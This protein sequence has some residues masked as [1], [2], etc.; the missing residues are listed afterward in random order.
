MRSA[1]PVAEKQNLPILHVNVISKRNIFGDFSPPTLFKYYG[2]C[3]VA[4]ISKKAEIQ[5]SNFPLLLSFFLHLWSRRP[6][7]SQLT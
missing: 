1:F 6:V 3:Q 2:M 5:T 4:V 7:F